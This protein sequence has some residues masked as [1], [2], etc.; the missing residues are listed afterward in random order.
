MEVAWTISDTPDRGRDPDP[1]KG[2]NV[3]STLGVGRASLLATLIIVLVVVK[4]FPSQHIFEN[5]AAY[6]PLHTAMEIFAIIIS[7]LIFAVGWHAH[8]RERAGNIVLISCAFLAVGLLDIAHA[9]SYP[10]M[11]D[12]VTPNSPGKAIHFWLAARWLAAFA[13]L[14]A[15]FRSWRPFVSYQARCWL[16]AA[17]FAVTALVY[18]LGVFHLDELPDTFIPGQG[19]TPFKIGLNML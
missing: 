10:G 4:V 9:L 2:D 3:F 11:P 1:Q 6:L 15:A 12:F 14:A 5:P 19:L 7:M 16:L 18:W 8:G 13:L 17:A